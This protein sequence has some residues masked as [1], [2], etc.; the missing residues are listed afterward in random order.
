MMKKI[1]GLFRRLFKDRGFRRGIRILFWA[2]IAYIIYNL[3]VY[4]NA[5]TDVGISLQDA[6]RFFFS[7]SPFAY[8]F[9]WRFFA[10]VFLAIVLGLIR[11]FMGK[12]ESRNTEENAGEEKPAEST[13]P[14]QEEELY[15]P[16]HYQYH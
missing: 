7:L 1:A 5:I 2:S 12:E 3:V 11:Y 14:V 15:E 10:V 13:D 8:P 6:I 16:K 9:A 4:L